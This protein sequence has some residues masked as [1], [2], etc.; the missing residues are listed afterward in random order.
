MSLLDQIRKAEDRG[1]YATV[2]A[3]LEQKMIEIR[4]RWLLAEE[5]QARS[6]ELNKPNERPF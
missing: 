4:K 1:D 6:K 3:L 5:I 2:M